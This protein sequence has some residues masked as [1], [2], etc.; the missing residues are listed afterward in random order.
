MRVEA[1]AGLSTEQRLLLARKLQERRAGAAAGPGRRWARRSLGLPMPLAEAVLRLAREAGYEPAEI[2]LAAWAGLLARYSGRDDALVATPILV[3]IA[4][5][6]TVAFRTLLARVRCALAEREGAVDAAGALLPAGFLFERTAARRPQVEDLPAAPRLVL[7][8]L[9]EA[10][11]LH[12]LLDFWA[13]RFAATDATRMLLHFA[14]LLERA[15]SDPDRALA[16]LDLLSAAERHQLVVEWRE[17][18][19]K[20]LDDGAAPGSS[21]PWLY[22]LDATRQPVPVGVAGELYVAGWGERGA[23]GEPGGLA[24]PSDPPGAHL[25]HGGRRAVRRPDGNLVLVAPVDGTAGDD[26]AAGG[27]G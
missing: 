13:D 24:V 22:L 25:W 11:R 23:G 14:R 6:G 10:S 17:V 20:I 12:C 7:R 19:R 5:C 3:R 8:V 2:L 18:G 27:Q 16:G 26:P 1:L 15:A 21:P 4:G 9:A